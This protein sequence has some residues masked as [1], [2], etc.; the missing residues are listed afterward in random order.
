MYWLYGSP[1]IFAASKQQLPPNL[2]LA[3]DDDAS[4]PVHDILSDPI[5]NSEAS[6]TSKE[7]ANG[8]AST[9]KVKERG[10]RGSRINGVYNEGTSALDEEL[11]GLCVSR[12]AHIFIT[13]TASTL[14]V[15]QTKPTTA[16]AA[17]VR[18]ARSLH[19]YG[20]NIGVVLRPDSAILVVQTSLGF[21]ITYSLAT[22]PN[23]RIYRP[24]FPESIAGHARHKSFS[25]RVVQR[26]DEPPSGAGEGAGVGEVSIQFRMVMRVNEGVS[27]IIALDDELILATKSPPVVHCIRWRR[28]STSAQ[29]S[30]AAL[31]SMAWMAPDSQV[32]EIVHDRPMNISTWI[33]KDGKAYAVQRTRSKSQEEEG[34]PSKLFKG[35]CFHTPENEGAYAGKAAIN[36]RFSLIAVGCADGTI[37]VYTARDYAGHIPLSHTLSAS[38]TASNIGKI[39]FL[40]YSPDGYCLFAGYQHGW[41]SW[42]VYGKPGVSSFIADRSLAKVNDEQWLLG[43]RDGFWIGS[44]SEI[45]LLS[46]LENRLWVMDMARSAVAG[47]FST[48]NVAR[49]LLQTSTGFMIYRGYDLP[50]LNA[51]SSEYG[52]WHHVQVPSNY[53]AHQWPIR[54]AV[55]STDGRY[56]AIA[57]R[58]GLAHYSVNSAR[59]KT[60]DDPAEED[61]FTVRGGMCWHR[62]LLIAAVESNESY[63]IRV[64]SR[65]TALD[66]SHVMHVEQMV[67][68]IVLIAPSGEDSLLVYTY[69]NNLHHYVINFTNRSVKLVQAGQIA[70]HG[71][72]RAPPRVRGL[73][74]ILPEEQLQD[75]DPSQDVALATLIFLV[76]GKLVTLQPSTNENGELKYDMRIVAHNVEYYG[77]MRDQPYFRLPNTSELNL[78]DLPTPEGAPS[79]DS[80]TQNDLR[81]SLWYFDGHDMNV[82]TDVSD[83]LTSTSPEFSHALPPPI[84]VPT[85]FYPLSILLNKGVLFG[86]EPD[87]V[88]RRDTTFSF[89]R[90]TTRTHLFL[91]P[92]LR[93]YLTT[94]NQPAALHL[95]HHYQSLSYFP[96]ALEVLL[97]DVLDESVDQKPLSRSPNPPSSSASS[98]SEG[99]S[100][101]PPLLPTVLSFLSSFPQFL[102]ILVQCTRKTELASWRTLFAHLPPPTQLFEDALARGL[103]KTAGGYL[104]VLHTLGAEDGEGGWEGSPG[105]GRKS[106]AERA[107]ESAKEGGQ[108]VRLLRRAREEGD[109]ELCREIARFLVALDGSGV[110]LREALEFAGLGMGERRGSDATIGPGVG[111]GLG[112]EPGSE[113]GS[114]SGSVG[115]TGMDYFGAK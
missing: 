21:L 75:G 94:Y 99:E 66:S 85:D 11:L 88:Q 13:I 2:T 5:G 27:S 53:L 89:L 54:S 74:W 9:D 28:D 83:I 60:F 40:A 15:W 35:F 38:V 91:P 109:W 39:T 50:D 46:E 69:E 23:A 104:L 92:I 48:A 29:T 14:T 20:T 77:L 32:A 113:S 36:A 105:L 43:I 68:P 61:E 62:H 30:T 51:L 84:K 56:V 107:I 7:E 22:D 4:T 72:I 10:R 24:I 49:S 102:D 82:W 101:K 44:G 34:K 100:D 3:S 57:G 41:A 16:V 95:S 64:Y 103:L 25:G 63:E 59:W 58:R 71:I 52:L 37:R 114:G 45:I 106:S 93:R 87:L 79:I 6:S 115:G 19:S 78:S 96:H 67:A 31:Q 90:F 33:T 86:V 8:D 55:I 108:A 12:N 111:I 73:S 98:A 112:I 70:L 110:V 47:C 81:D 26:G 65:E 76:D 80:F 17:V 1:S 97:H 42:S 18:S